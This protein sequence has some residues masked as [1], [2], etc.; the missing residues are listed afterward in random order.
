MIEIPVKYE[1]SFFADIQ[2]I[3]PSA[4][5]IPVLL[6][7]FRDRGL[8]PIIFHEIG[9]G[10]LGPNPRLS[11]VSPDN[12]WSIA[13][14]GERIIFVKNMSKPK[15]V[16]MG[17]VDEF[18]KVVVEFSKRILER[19]PVKGTRLALVTEGMMT[20][21]SDKSLQKVY[22]KVF[23]PVPFYVD[24]HPTEW[25]SRAA[26]RIDV[27]INGREE[28]LNVLTK[29]NRMQG[30]FRLQDGTTPF[31]LIKVSFDI[32]T[33]QGNTETRFDAK[34]VAEFCPKALDLRANV[35]SQVEVLV[36]G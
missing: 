26:A 8:L 27:Q 13:F 28:S 17:T 29:V 33:F 16:N 30:E 32:N 1:A 2:D 15:G 4:D 25:G 10:L 36:N 14:P 6:D 7:M 18:G 20:E 11:L 9:G 35:L 19:F 5:T 12:E 22:E 23:R 21:M 31:D 3:R 24:N 34:S